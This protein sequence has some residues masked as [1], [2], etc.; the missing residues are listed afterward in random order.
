[1]NF[2]ILPALFISVNQPCGTNK[3]N[4]EEPE[5]TESGPPN[6]VSSEATRSLLLYIYYTIQY[7]I[8]YEK[9]FKGILAAQICV[10]LHKTKID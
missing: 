6:L 10:A 7:K 1:M 9:H 5:T 2:Y 8:S 4:V 3:Y